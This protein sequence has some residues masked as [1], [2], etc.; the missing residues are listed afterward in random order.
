[1][2]NANK[3]GINYHVKNWQDTWSK[4]NAYITNGS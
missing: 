3:K 1:L 4:L 2:A